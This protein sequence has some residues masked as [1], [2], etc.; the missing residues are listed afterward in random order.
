MTHFFAS[1]ARM[2]HLRHPRYN[3]RLGTLSAA[4]RSGAAALSVAFFGLLGL[5]D[6]AASQSAGNP[7]TM[8]SS[9]FEITSRLQ[10]IDQQL[11]LAGTK[12]K[13]RDRLS[14]EATML[15][16]RLQEGDFR[17]GERFMLTLIKDTVRT[18]SVTVRDSLLIG[19]SNLPDMSLR[20]VLRSELTPRL[21]AF[22]AEF[23]LNTGV[24]TQILTRVSVMGEVG[25]P[26]FYYL[27]PDR[28]ISEA[29]T[30]AGG[31]TTKANIKRLEVFRG[32]KTILSAKKSEQAVKEGKTLEQLNIQSGDEIRI[33]STRTFNWSLIVQLLL[34]ASSLFFALINLLR[35]YY[36]QQQI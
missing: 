7:I 31:P 30:T 14:D 17:V 10:Q 21:T 36:S 25:R 4:F 27:A 22:V 28:P 24:R 20:G 2:T 16:N 5:S 29:L 18:D 3:P 23:L 33:P 19:I 13:Q 11:A 34:L 6:A 8:S 12:G 26:G 15:R 32:G 9:R 1:M 35:F